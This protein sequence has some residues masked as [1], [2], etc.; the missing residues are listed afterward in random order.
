MNLPEYKKKPSQL[1]LTVNTNTKREANNL[2]L[3]L[4]EILQEEMGYEKGEFIIKITSL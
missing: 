2:R 3:V 1:V 4:K